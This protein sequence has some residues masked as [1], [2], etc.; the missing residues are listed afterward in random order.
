MAEAQASFTSLELR[1]VM[2][3]L[4]LQGK[5]AKDIHTEMSQTL[6][7]KCPSY[8]TVKTWISRFKTGHFT[9]EDEPRSGRPTTS[10]DPETCDAV[11][12]L[13][14]EDRRISAKKIAQ[15]VDIS[16]E[17]VG[18]II[19]TILDMRKLSAKWVP[20]CLNSD[21]KKERVQASKAILGH[22]ESTPDFLARLVTEDETWL[23][24]YDPETKEQSKEWRHSG[25]PRPKKFRTQKSA[26]KV[27]ASVFWDKDGILLVDYLPQGSS[28][29]GQYYANLLDQLKE[30][31]KKKRRGK[32]TE[33]I[34][35]L[36]DNAPAHTSNV[37]AAK[38]NTLGFQLVHHPPYSPDLAPSDYY[39]FPNLKKHLKGHRFE[40][41]SDVK[42][43]AES[44]FQDQSKEFYLD[45]LEKL[46]QRC[47]K[48]ISLRGEYVE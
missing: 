25:S 11:H 40:D 45:G 43:A 8:S 36:Q 46:Q 27:M 18:F 31:I 10:T 41:I 29:T 32:L 2:K 47:N 42:H 14:L 13:I 30:A 4:F 22:F 9:V 6:G 1:A 17:R 37:V 15:I 21:Q 48:C 24:I 19:T 34:L 12:E 35:F 39:L 5:S 16:R 23:Y 33:G 7:E 28:I 38:L 3:F 20:K 26:K 44:W